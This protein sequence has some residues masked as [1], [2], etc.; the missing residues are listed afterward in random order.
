MITALADW[1][2]F[3]RTAL[4]RADLLEE[5][6]HAEEWSAVARHQAEAREFG[7]RAGTRVTDAWPD[8]YG[9]DPIVFG[10]R[11]GGKRRG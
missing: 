9:P 3:R 5:S 11:P 2:G 8:P 1:F 6:R 10:L 7:E 4:G